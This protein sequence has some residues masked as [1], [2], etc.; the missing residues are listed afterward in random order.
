M[1]ISL[2]NTTIIK[3]Y[4]NA[5]LPPLLW[6]VIIFALSSQSNLPSPDS[7]TFNFIFK[8]SA[9]ITVFAVFF[10][11]LSRGLHITQPRF[12]LKKNWYIPIGICLFYA[13]SDEVHQSFVSYRHSSIADIGYDM[14]GVLTMYLYKIGYI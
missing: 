11:L 14:L 2:R 4:L 8:K 10:L 7:S 13:V 12:D 6:A 3:K 9:H 1:I 5:Y